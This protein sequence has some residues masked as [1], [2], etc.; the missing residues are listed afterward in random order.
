MARGGVV[1]ASSTVAPAYAEQVGQRLAQHGL[2]MIDA[3]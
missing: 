2:Y 1:I 3:R